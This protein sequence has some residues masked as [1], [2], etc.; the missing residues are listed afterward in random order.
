MP[1]PFTAFETLSQMEP[2]IAFHAATA[3][4][5][6][7]LTPFV[8]WRR[9]RDH[10]HKKLGYIWVTAM[11]L[12]ALSAFTIS[13]IGGVGRFSLLHGLAVLTLWTLVVAIRMAIKGDIKGHQAA[14]RNLATFGLGLP[15]VLTFLPH[16]TFQKAFSAESPWAGLVVMSVIYIAVI[17]WRTKRRK[18]YSARSVLA[19]RRVN[20]ADLFQ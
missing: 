12:T 9:K 8:L 14:L 19:P 17:V 4:L 2:N 10:L 16:R 11:A 18:R 1:A 6:F 3:T 15:M 13:N 7:C 20:G 5:A